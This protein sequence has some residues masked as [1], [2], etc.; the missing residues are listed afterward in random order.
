MVLVYRFNLPDLKPR[1]K[2]IPE[3]ETWEPDDSR[4]YRPRILY[5]GVSNS[6]EI[7]PS[8]VYD[9]GDTHRDVAVAVPTGANAMTT[10]K[11]KAKARKTSPKKKSVAKRAAKTNGTGHVGTIDVIVATISRDKGATVQECLAVLKSKFPDRELMIG[12]V[13]TQVHRHSTKSER[14]E[15]RGL[16]YFGSGR[17]DQS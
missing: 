3:P 12:T 16:I 6:G 17:R 7:Q 11:A 14:D 13:R 9:H 1:P 2:I 10:K 15:K 5:R 8:V 4:W